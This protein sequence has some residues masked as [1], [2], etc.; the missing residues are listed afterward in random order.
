MKN[1][2]NQ[3]PEQDPAE[4]SSEIIDRDL[5]RQGGKKTVDVSKKEQQAAEPGSEAA[6]PSPE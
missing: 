3:H 6:E 1:T 2:E 4:G 5:A